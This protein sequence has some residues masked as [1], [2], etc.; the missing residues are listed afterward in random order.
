MEIIMHRSSFIVFLLVLT[1]PV[2]FATHAP[3][4]EGVSAA[5]IVREMNLARENPALY[6]T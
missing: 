3:D 6:A 1:A 2:L 4:G 5:A